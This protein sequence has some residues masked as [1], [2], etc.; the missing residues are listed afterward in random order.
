MFRNYLFIFLLYL[1]GVTVF[2]VEVK[3]R[4]EEGI[5]IKIVKG[6]IVGKEYKKKKKKKVINKFICISN[7]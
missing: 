3:E 5:F 6:I 4:I 7:V 1:V 2:E